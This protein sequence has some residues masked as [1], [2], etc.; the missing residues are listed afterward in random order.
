MNPGGTGKDRAA[1]S[2]LNE[3]ELEGKL[4]K[5]G[6][7]TEGTSGRYVQC[8]FDGSS[9]FLI[10]WFST[11]ISLAC[12]CKSRGYHLKIVMPDDQAAEKKALLQRYVFL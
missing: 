9:F 1:L 3:A 6:I 7:V 8:V 12:L 4:K 5:G 10:S 11:G 2:M